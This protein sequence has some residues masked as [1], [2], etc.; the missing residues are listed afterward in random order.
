[1]TRLTYGTG[2]TH[3]GPEVRPSESTVRGAT[4]C[5]LPR[6][7]SPEDKRKRR[8]KKNGERAVTG[9]KASRADRARGRAYVRRKN[10]E[11]GRCAA[12]PPAQGRRR[13]QLRAKQHAG[14]SLF[15]DTYDHAHRFENRHESFLRDAAVSTARLA[16]LPH[17]SFEQPI[18]LIN[19]FVNNE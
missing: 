18:N 9:G 12:R 4:H 8:A 10:E 5:R 7:T 11:D 14:A 2:R 17:I 15:R 1:M 13:S 3:S 6:E 19:F 16:Q